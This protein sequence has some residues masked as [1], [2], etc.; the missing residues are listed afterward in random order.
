M[1]AENSSCNAA[2]T[3]GTGEARGDSPFTVVRAHVES[4]ETLSPNFVRIVFI[5]SDLVGVGNPGHTYDQRVKLILPSTNGVLPDI[6]GTGLGWYQAWLDTPEHLRGVMRTYTIREVRVA[7]D[8]QTRVVIDFVL[9][10]DSGD[11]GPASRWAD[12]ASPGDSIL[13]AAPRRGRLDGGGI[14]YTPG[15]ART[16]LLAGDETAV[17]AIASILEDVSSNA[18]G[19]AFIEVPVSEDQLPLVAPQGFEVRWLPRGEQPHGSQLISA[20]LEYLGSSV[21]RTR[22]EDI[23]TE[24]PLWETPTFSGLGEAVCPGGES[25]GERFFWIAGESAVV[26]TLRRHLVRE[27][28]IDRSR[29]AFMGYWR[30]G[31][32]M[33][34]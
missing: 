24:D 2:P 32:A 6:T 25:S 31:V 13:I 26:T 33:R 15:D 34:G 21:E 9:H 28:G 22:I 27:Y 12:A 19:I 16:V 8:G 11:T 20:V 14:E 17:P 29:V 23:K 4:V 3:Q 18:R 30:R 10:S 5:G 7:P 1:S